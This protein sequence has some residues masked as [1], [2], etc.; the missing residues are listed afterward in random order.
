MDVRTQV[1]KR[2]AT[3]IDKK[4]KDYCTAQLFGAVF[5]VA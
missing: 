4:N 2:L 5:L 1:A 3:M